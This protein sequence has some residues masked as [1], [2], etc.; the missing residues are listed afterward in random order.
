MIGIVIAS[1]AWRIAPY[2]GEDLTMDLVA[3][4]VLRE[5]GVL[6]TAILVAAPGSPSPPRSAS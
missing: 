5:M 3:V 6:I 2:G 4:S 1:K